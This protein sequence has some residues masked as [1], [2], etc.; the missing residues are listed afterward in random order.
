[1]PGGSSASWFGRGGYLAQCDARGQTI[2]CPCG[3]EM[4]DA[5]LAPPGTSR[6]ESV[7]MRASTLSCDKRQV[8]QSDVI[9]EIKPSA[10]RLAQCLRKQA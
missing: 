9:V 5:A 4:V 6:V 7:R 2:A 1:M 3:Q 10:G 8:F